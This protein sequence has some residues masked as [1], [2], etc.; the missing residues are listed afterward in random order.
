M[1]VIIVVS[2]ILAII[3][4]LIVWAKWVEYTIGKGTAGFSVY[5]LGIVLTLGAICVTVIR[6]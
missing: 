3:S 2:A 4:T 1:T 5:I 6:S